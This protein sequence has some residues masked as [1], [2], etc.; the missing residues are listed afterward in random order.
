MENLRRGF[1]RLLD[2]IIIL[3]TFFHRDIL[4]LA[5]TNVNLK[6]WQVNGMT[7][8]RLLTHL[9]GPPNLHTVRG[10]HH[11]WLVVRNEMQVVSR[12]PHLS[13]MGHPS[14]NAGNGEKYREEIHWEP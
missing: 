6:E 4:S 3:F 8:P 7:M 5:R 1:G 14:N 10:K 12:C 11:L 2:V 13:P 9:A